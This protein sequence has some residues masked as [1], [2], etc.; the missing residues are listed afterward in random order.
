MTIDE[1]PKNRG[2]TLSDGSKMK[3]Q[4]VLYDTNVR[5]ASHAEE[6]RLSLIHI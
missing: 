1:Q 4:E 2:H 6:A 5:R 3:V